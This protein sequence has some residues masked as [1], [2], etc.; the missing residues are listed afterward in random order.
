MFRDGWKGGHMEAGNLFQRE[1]RFSRVFPVTLNDP[2]S[3]KV[4]CTVDQCI[5]G[6]KGVESGPVKSISFKD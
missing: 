2:C 6:N 3:V 1:S 4:V 5:N